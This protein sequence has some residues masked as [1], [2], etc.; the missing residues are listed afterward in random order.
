MNPAITNLVTFCATAPPHVVKL[1]ISE[2]IFIPYIINLR[3]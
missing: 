3:I 1:L 2:P